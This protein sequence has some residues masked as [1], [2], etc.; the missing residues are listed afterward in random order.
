VR[1]DQLVWMYGA[2]EDEMRRLARTLHPVGR[3]V[4]DDMETE[5][6]AAILRS[7][8]AERLVDGISLHTE[9]DARLAC[10]DG[11][12]PVGCAP[13]SG[14]G[15]MLVA[16]IPRDGTYLVVG[17]VLEHV[18]VTEVVVNDVAIPTVTAACGQAFSQ[19]GVEPGYTTIRF[20]DA[21]GGVGAYYFDLP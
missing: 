14:Y 20:D 7:A 15:P 16:T 2:D 21:P 3:D 8:D 11:Q 18:P 17:C 19:G 5:A 4:L 6:R 12:E 1:G 9:G 13:A 10:V